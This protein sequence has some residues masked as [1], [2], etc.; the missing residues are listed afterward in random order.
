MV[1]RGLQVGHINLKWARGSTKGET[2]SRCV[3]SSE[4]EM[5]FGEREVQNQ[6]TG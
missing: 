2:I 4:D 5:V 1:H 6:K 3:L